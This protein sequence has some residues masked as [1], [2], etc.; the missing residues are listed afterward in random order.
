MYELELSTCR[1]AFASTIRLGDTRRWQ[2][3]TL[4]DVYLNVGDTL[5]IEVFDTYPGK[6]EQTAAIT[7]IVLHGAH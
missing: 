1:S 2:H 4:P 3:V 5:A 7:E 6:K